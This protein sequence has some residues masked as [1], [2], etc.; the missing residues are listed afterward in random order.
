MPVNYTAQEQASTQQNLAG[1]K[2]E[3]LCASM[4]GQKPPRA[5]T[6]TIMRL[7]IIQST[8]QQASLVPQNSTKGTNLGAKRPLTS[9]GLPSAGQTLRIS[10][11]GQKAPVNAHAK[12]CQISFAKFS[13]NAK[14]QCRHKRARKPVPTT[15]MRLSRS[16][17]ARGSQKGIGMH[18]DL[19]RLT[20]Q[21]G[22]TQM[23]NDAI[24]H[25]SP[26]AM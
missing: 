8:R 2:R 23:Q 12:K 21:R 10:A 15:K 18:Q 14:R 3:D 16:R 17:P 19:R 4:G 9:M 24:F 11:Y 20:L 6:P 25:T 7:N 5:T 26:C 13:T 1:L 22:V